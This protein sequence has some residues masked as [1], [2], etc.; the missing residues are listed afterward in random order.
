[1]LRIIHGHVTFVVNH[2]Q[3]EPRIGAGS[4]HNVIAHQAL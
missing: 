2:G 3:V 1:V 4:R